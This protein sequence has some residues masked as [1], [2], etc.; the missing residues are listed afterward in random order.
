MSIQQTQTIQ[1][2]TSSANDDTNYNYT[3]EE[4]EDVLQWDKLLQQELSWLGTDLKPNKPP[5]PPK[6]S[7]QLKKFFSELETTFLDITFKYLKTPK[8]KNRYTSRDPISRQV[9]STLSLLK[10]TNKVV[11]PTNK[12]NGFFVILITK[13]VMTMEQN[14]AVICNPISV[15]K[16]KQFHSES[17]LLFDEVKDSLSKKESAMVLEGL[18]SCSVPVARFLIKDNKLKK[19][20]N[21]DYPVQLIFPEEDYNYSYSK[22]GYVFIRDVLQRNCVSIDKYNIVQ[23]SSLKENLLDL[24]ITKDSNSIASLDIVNFYPSVL[25]TMIEKAV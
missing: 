16:V 10:D 22:L 5:P 25:F 12:I 18:R 8:N 2:N 20:L 14:L 15:S 23:A 3:K 1:G 13:Y 17:L 4:W 21:E 11:I 19:K 9:E 7:E 6:G 24:G